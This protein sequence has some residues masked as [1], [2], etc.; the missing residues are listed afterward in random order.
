M[1]PGRIEESMAEHGQL[2]EAF[3]SGDE[4]TAEKVA[5]DH[6]QQTRKYYIRL[7]GD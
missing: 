4:D 2:I 1:F 7:A 5:R 6:F 3:K